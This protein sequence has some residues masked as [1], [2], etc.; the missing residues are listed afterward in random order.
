MSDL[1]E[2]PV[3]QP[4]R[5]KAFQLT[6]P[7]FV[8]AAKKSLLAEID[9]SIPELGYSTTLEVYGRYDRGDSSVGIPAGHVVERIKL[10]DDHLYDEKLARACEAYCNENC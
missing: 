7:E 1:P 2:I 4:I 9:I 3:L 6:A 5:N 8:E 10:G